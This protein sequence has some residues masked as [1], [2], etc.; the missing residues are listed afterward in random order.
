MLQLDDL[1]GPGE[2]V[3]RERVVVVAQH[4]VGMWKLRE[5]PVE[6]GLPVRAGEQV[7]G[8]ANEVGL[9]RGDP[10]FC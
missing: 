8:D 5:Q 3:T 10:R 2:R 4:D 1:D 6:L 7:A 9:P